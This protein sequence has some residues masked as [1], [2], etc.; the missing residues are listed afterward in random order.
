M[1]GHNLDF[2]SRLLAD[3]YH[4]AGRNSEAQALFAKLLGLC[5]D[6]GLS[7]EYAPEERR[8]VGD[9]PQAFSHI[10]L[11]NIAHRLSQ[12]RMQQVRSP[13]GRDQKVEERPR[14]K[15]ARPALASRLQR[16]NG[17]TWLR[18]SPNEPTRRNSTRIS[19]PSHEIGQNDP[20]SAVLMG[21]CRRKQ[22]G[23]RPRIFP[24]AT[25]SHATATSSGAV[26]CYLCLEILILPSRSAHG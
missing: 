4:L 15:I 11:I 13:G 24:N 10:A 20:P 3:A 16:Q 18:R 9:F 23:S 25:A 21:L 1:A 14:K 2:S 12:I 6:L 22:H 8:L 7:E 17:E 19:V 26:L 5:N